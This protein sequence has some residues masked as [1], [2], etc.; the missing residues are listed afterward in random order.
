MSRRAVFRCV[1]HL[2]VPYTYLYSLVNLR[3]GYGPPGS[4]SP[5]CPRLGFV[6]VR[7]VLAPAHRVTLK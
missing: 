6:G 1:S 2:S 3:R 5:V 7:Y 4:C